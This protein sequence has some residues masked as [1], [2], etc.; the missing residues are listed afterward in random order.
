[1]T[2]DAADENIGK[3]GLPLKQSFGLRL[4][5]ETIAQI[6]EMAE[7]EKSSVPVFIERTME[8]LHKSYKRSRPRPKS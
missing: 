7:A 6:K 5:P 2:E 3:R 8:R 1:M 4:K